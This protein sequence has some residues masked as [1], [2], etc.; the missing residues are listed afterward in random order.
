MDVIGK[1]LMK[2]G[3]KPDTARCSHCDIRGVS[4]IAGVWH[5]VQCGAVQIYLQA[6]SDVF[7]AFAESG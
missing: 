2:V 3:E 4:A 6:L 7:R 5:F 1:N